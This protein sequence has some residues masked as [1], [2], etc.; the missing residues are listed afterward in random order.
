[1]VK[2]VD[3]YDSNVC[4]FS[5]NYFTITKEKNPT[6]DTNDTPG[7]EFIIVLLTIIAIML[8]KRYPR[9]NF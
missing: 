6:I 5:D 4:D 3:Y 9:M 8:M 7:F 2:V 1:M